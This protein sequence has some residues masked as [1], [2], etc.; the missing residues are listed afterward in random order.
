MRYCSSF[1]STLTRSWQF[2]QP[3]QIWVKTWTAEHTTIVTYNSDLDILNKPI[4]Q[5]QNFITNSQVY[6]LGINEL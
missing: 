4:A 1:N 5:V 2:D 3:Y 6:N